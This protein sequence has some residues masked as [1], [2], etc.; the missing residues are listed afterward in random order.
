MHNE[1][2]L[3][4]YFLRHYETF[5]DRIFIIDAYSTDRTREIAFKHPKVTL[6]HCPYGEKFTEDDVS[7]CYERYYKE[8]RIRE[9]RLGNVVDGDEFVYHP[10][11][12][13]ALQHAEDKEADVIRTT[14][15]TMVSDHLPTTTGQIYKES[16]GVLGHYHRINR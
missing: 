10:D 4:P 6:L 15:Y 3:L 1:E 12:Q 5:A 13:Q 7:H 9:T 2:V 16:M 14:C 8:F 11:I